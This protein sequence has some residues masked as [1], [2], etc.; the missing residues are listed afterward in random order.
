MKKKSKS[1]HNILDKF[2]EIESKQAKLF[3]AINRAQEKLKNAVKMNTKIK[4]KLK[5]SREL[6]EK[7]LQA[8]KDNP[9]LGCFLKGIIEKIL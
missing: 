2:D 4:S 8:A 7:F 9:E 6:Q 1:S 5:K 3:D